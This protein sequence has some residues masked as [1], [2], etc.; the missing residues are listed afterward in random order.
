LV[1]GS[2]VVLIGAVDEEV[3]LAG[4]MWAV[5][6][7]GHRGGR[8]P[9]IDFALHGR[10]LALVA[11]IAGAQ[12]LAD[13]IHDVSAGGLAV[14]LAEMAVRSGVGFRV[15]GFTDHAALFGEGPSRVVLSVPGAALERV[16]D[17][18]RS[19]DVPARVIGEAGGDRIVFEGLL[20]VGVHE[21]A[22]AWRGSLPLA[23]TGSAG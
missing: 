3:S 15:S 10:L 17:L 18:A 20:D 22:A 8:L 2:S 11:G 4:S 7:R 12:D 1:Q 5:Q 19:G 16:L 14:A 21:T 9:G 23:L 13:G 6:R